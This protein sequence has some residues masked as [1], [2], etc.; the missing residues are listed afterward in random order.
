[1]EVRMFKKILLTGLCLSTAVFAAE[2]QKDFEMHGELSYV[3]TSG[4]S[5]TET[6]ATKIEAKKKLELNRLFGKGEFLYGKTDDKENTNKLYLLGRWERLLSDRLFFFLQGDYLRDKFSGYDYQTTW[7]GGFGYDIIKTK[8]HYLKGLA[9]VGYTFEDFKTG[10]SDDYTTGTIELDY[11][12]QILDNLK[13]IEEFKYRVNLED[14]ETYFINSDTGIQV[15]INSHFSL[16]VGYR[17][18]YQN[19]PPSD[20]IEKT[21]TTFLTSL[22]IDY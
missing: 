3:K 5:D 18:A 4:N 1:M 6:F 8:K 15:K 20:D 11:N 7:S 13:F 21:D 22:I 2:Q 19:N 12:W 17:I 16:G 9:A 10:G 14:T